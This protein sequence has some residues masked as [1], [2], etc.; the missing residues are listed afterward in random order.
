MAGFTAL[1]TT[2][3]AGRLDAAT[4]ERAGAGAVAGLRLA[5]DGPVVADTLAATPH[6]VAPV[7]FAALCDILD[8]IASDLIRPSDA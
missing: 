5:T 2:P 7:K 8:R 3:D 1:H 4:W 6:G